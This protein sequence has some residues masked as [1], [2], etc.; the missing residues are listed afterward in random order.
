MKKHHENS[1]KGHTFVEE[2]LSLLYA[3]KKKRWN[4]LEIISGLDHLSYCMRNGSTKLK[5]L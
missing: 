3:N 2:Q 1:L 5:T 4:K